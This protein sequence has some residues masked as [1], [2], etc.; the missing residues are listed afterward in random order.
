MTAELQAWRFSDSKSDAGG[1]KSARGLGEP[2][3]RK[4]TAELIAEA[5]VNYSGRE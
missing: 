5:R 2:L 4:E 1:T 3:L